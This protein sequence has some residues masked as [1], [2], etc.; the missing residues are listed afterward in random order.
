MI[1]RKR[2]QIFTAILSIDDGQVANRLF[3]MLHLSLENEQNNFSL[4]RASGVF[5]VDY[6]KTAVSKHANCKGL[7][8]H[9]LP[10]TVSIILKALF[11][12]QTD[13]NSLNYF[14]DILFQISKTSFPEY[15]QTFKEGFEAYFQHLNGRD[16]NLLSNRQHFQR[17]LTCVIK[18]RS[19]RNRFR[20]Y[21]KEW[22][23]LSQNLTKAES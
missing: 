3:E 1:M 14:S 8:H 5:L 23:L 20:E 13:L 17:N 9:F 4:I 15:N 6:W 10:R 19:N 12:Q 2:F 7:A 11:A 18:E 16:D 22:F 21:C